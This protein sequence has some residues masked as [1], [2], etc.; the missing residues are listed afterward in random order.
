MCM[1]RSTSGIAACITRAPPLLKEL[2]TAST[3]TSLY[4]DNLVD[5]DIMALRIEGHADARRAF[6]RTA[7]TSRSGEKCRAR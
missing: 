7:K 2:R 6:D 4:V 1:P 3:V 5:Q